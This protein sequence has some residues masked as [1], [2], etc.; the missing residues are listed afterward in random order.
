[1]FDLLPT[2]KRNPSSLPQRFRPFMCKMNYYIVFYRVKAGSV[3]T[4]LARECGEPLH[5]HGQIC[6]ISALE[7]FGLGPRDDDLLEP[8]VAR[9]R[10]NTRA[11]SSAT[12]RTSSSP[13]FRS[14]TGEVLGDQTHEPDHAPL[15]SL[16][17]QTTPNAAPLGD[18]VLALPG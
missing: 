8:T 1:M 14:A 12:R 3:V 7:L 11:S 13:P 4:R 16:N 6:R 9:F 5:E 18:T 15:P 17:T 2:Q 10:E